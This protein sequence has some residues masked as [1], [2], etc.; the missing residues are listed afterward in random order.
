MIKKILKQEL[1]SFL[2]FTA[3]FLCISSCTKGSLDP[4]DW[5][6]GMRH[7]DFDKSLVKSEAE[8]KAEAK[9]KNTEEEPIPESAKLLLPPP[10]KTSAI[11]KTISFAVSEKVP[12]KD[13]LIELGRVAKI[14]IDLDPSITGGIL[15]NAR[16]R[17][18]EEVIDRIAR[19]GNLRYTYENNILHFERDTPYVKNYIL[20]YLSEGSAVWNDVQGN[21]S[22][23]L[24]DSYG[25]ATIALNAA[26]ATSSTGASNTSDNTTNASV[27]MAKSSI[28]VNK[29]AGILYVFATKRQHEEVE[30]YLHEVEKN[31]SAQVLIEAKFVEVTL[32]SVFSAGIN[33]NFTDLK[34]D[35]TTTRSFGSTNSYASGSAVDL[36]FGV[37]G[38]RGL[39]AAVSALEEFGTVRTLSS[40]RIHAINNQKAVLNFS[41]KIIYFKIDNNQNTSTTSAS[42][43]VNTQ[44]LT[45]TKQEENVGVEL[46]IIPS[47]NLKTSEITLN[48]KP[49]ITVKS[50][51]VVDPASPIVKDSSGKVIES[52]QNKVPIIQ[53]REINTVAKIQSGNVFV[54]GGLMKDTTNNTDSGIP[55]LQRIP[56]LGYLFKSSSKDSTVV[57]TVIFIKA[58]IIDS[59][60]RIGKIDR[61]LQRKF[62]T[63][64]REFF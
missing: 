8:R 50:G 24:S 56:I 41:D 32:K 6:I 27:P 63:N 9:K 37:I 34:G 51:E 12:L 55:F 48:L 33:W 11:N 39:H 2:A 28:S 38:A 57:E 4:M 15:I 53:T 45:S 59:G 5:Q 43:S 60:T 17:P 31:S 58:T 25:A 1:F 42:A 23:I 7:S 10:P 40:P 20:D 21:V 3:I 47:I 16:N 54:I 22:T 61:E 52:F 29:S 14:D 26:N 30:N 46:T 64:K 19:L 13:V 49:K 44:T 35:G 62:D 36:K 18:L